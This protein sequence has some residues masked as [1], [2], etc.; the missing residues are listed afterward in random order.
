MEGQ[1]RGYATA[2]SYSLRFPSSVAHPISINPPSIRI[3]CGGISLFGGSFSFLSGQA[4]MQHLQGILTNSAWLAFDMALDTLCP[5]CSALMKAAEAMAQKLNSMSINDCNMAKGL[6]AN[7]QPA[8]EGVANAIFEGGGFDS[9]SNGFSSSFSAYQSQFSNTFNTNN[10]MNFYTANNING[11]SGNHPF[12]GACGGF[13]NDIFP[14]G[15]GSYPISLMQQVA[16]SSTGASAMPADYQKAM[17]G[18]VGDIKINED[19]TSVYIPPCAENYDLDLQRMGATDNIYVQPGLA[20]TGQPAYTSMA[21][22][23]CVQS[24][25]SLS[26]FK[27]Y[28]NG[29]LTKVASGLQNMTA[30]QQPEIDF[31]SNTPGAVLFTLR[32]AIATGQLG[33]MQDSLAELDSELLM[34]AS[35]RDLASY[36]T[37]INSL[38]MQASPGFTN[39]TPPGNVNNAA[40]AGGACDL[41]LLVKGGIKEKLEYFRLSINHVADKVNENMKASLDQFTKNFQLAQQIQ[42]MDEQ[43]RATVSKNLGPAL[44]A[45]ATR[46]LH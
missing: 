44:A 46:Y 5:K 24:N 7:M 20:G 33:T 32:M 38:V 6:T 10:L 31:I 4:L 34:G 29:E 26:S 17:V 1:A 8:M 30:L 2:G 15:T 43:M 14:S 3:G 45:R 11:S 27:S 22:A 28:V 16:T 13:F 41:S 19:L 37:K 35:I 36:A 40:P 23:G 42:L 12:T 9:I 21:S 39:Q 18:L 25:V